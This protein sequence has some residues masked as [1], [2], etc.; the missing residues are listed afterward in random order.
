MIA[1]TD[2]DGAVKLWDVRMV[3]EILTVECSK[4]PANKAAFDASGAVSCS[5]HLSAGRIG[6]AKASCYGRRM[7]CA[8]IC[9]HKCQLSLCPP[10]T[11]LAGN[12]TKNAENAC[13][14][15]PRMA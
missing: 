12:L 2:A 13:R 4:Y 3:A 7:L 14:C 9:C 8:A 15:I 11:H 1:S 6:D 10:L 5:W